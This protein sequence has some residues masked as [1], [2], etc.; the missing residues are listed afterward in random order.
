VAVSAV[1]LVDSG[2]APR[3]LP[4]GAARLVPGPSFVDGPSLEDDLG[5]G[6]L[7]ARLILAAAPTAELHV[8]RVFGR[9]P[10][11]PTARLLEAVAA[12]LG[13]PVGF[14][15][16][17]AGVLDAATIPAWRE[18]LAKAATQGIRVV[19]PAAWQGRPAYPGSLAGAD[20]V[21][22]DPGCHARGPER[23]TLALGRSFLWASPL[24]EEGGRG[25]CGASL[26]AARATG[27]LLA[28]EASRE[29][30]KG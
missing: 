12:A 5:H 10:A 21:L 19:A 22:E 7:A 26:A 9:T 3:G 24:P 11:A 14:V 1:A 29:L 17:S 30:G 13:L 27:W 8:I 2:V 20:G 4:G 18:L 6:T 28:G 16:L 25:P 15:H 23:R